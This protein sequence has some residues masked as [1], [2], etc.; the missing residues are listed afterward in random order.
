MISDDGN[1]SP[2]KNH[3][4]ENNLLNHDE[5]KN[6]TISNDIEK[7]EKLKKSNLNNPIIAYYNINSLRNKMHDLRGIIS[8]A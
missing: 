7:F 6:T 5:N 3:I 8:R 2:Q 4:I 1:S